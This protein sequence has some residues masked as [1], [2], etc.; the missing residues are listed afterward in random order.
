VIH[1][2]HAVALAASA[3][4]CALLAQLPE[5]STLVYTR[6]NTRRQDRVPERCGFKAAAIH[7]IGVR[8][9]QS[10]AR[11]FK[12]ANSRAR[13][14]DIAAR[15]LD[16]EPA[17]G[18]VLDLPHVAEDYAQR[19]RRTGTPEQVG[20]AVT[21]ITQEES[22]QFRAVRDYMQCPLELVPLPGFEA[23]EAFDP[24]RDPPPQR[25]WRAQRIRPAGGGA[26]RAKSEAPTT[27]MRQR[28]RGRRDRA[29]GV[30]DATRPSARRVHAPVAA[31]AVIDAEA[32]EDAEQPGD[33]QP[34]SN[35]N[36]GARAARPSNGEIRAQRSSGA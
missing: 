10:R 34:T 22:P 11:G 2:I 26:G 17:D 4:C 8:S 27:A 14:T 31:A 35:A 24:E 5:Q 9:A 20:L 18:A 30:R 19:A 6:A 21:I 15:L 1:R 16:F 28:G 25:G 29:V 32:A 23:A 33:R 36:N 7:G 3:M 12:T 13:I